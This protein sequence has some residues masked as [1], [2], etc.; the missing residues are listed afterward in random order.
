MEARP[1]LKIELSK[2]DKFIETLCII[3]LVAL[4]VGTIAFFSKLPDQIPSHFN[5]AGQADD[6]SNK[7]HIFVLPIV[8]TIIYV[9]MTF[10]NKRPHIYNYLTTV[11]IENARQLYTSA[12]RLIRVLKLAVVVIF[13]GIVFMTHKTSLANGGG[14]EAWFLPFLLL[15]MTVPNIFYLL[16]SSDSK[17]PSR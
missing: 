5:A 15:L 3:I 9:G 17:Q 8:A 11:T 10:L 13:S 16:K 2:I 1:K 12:T 4:W 7:K 6:F 14:L